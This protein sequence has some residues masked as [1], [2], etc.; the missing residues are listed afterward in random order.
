MAEHERG[1]YETLITEA[2]EEQL[3]LLGDRLEARRSDLHEAEAADRLRTGKTS[4]SIVPLDATSWTYRYDPTRPEAA[5]T[6]LQIDDI[7]VDSMRGR[8]TTWTCIRINL[9]HVPEGERPAEEAPDPDYDPWRSPGRERPGS[10]VTPLQCAGD[11]AEPT[12]G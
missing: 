10:A 6:R 12:S 3:G 1:L 7:L 9:R 11:Q 8:S 2:L 5:A 4:V